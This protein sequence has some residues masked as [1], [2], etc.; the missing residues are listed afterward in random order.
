MRY[1]HV[2]WNIVS[3]VGKNKPY[4]CLI[5]SSKFHHSVLFI[6][7]SHLAYS[8][9]CHKEDKVSRTG[10]KY[11]SATLYIVLA[12]SENSFSVIDLSRSEFDIDIN[13]R[14]LDMSPLGNHE[15]A[16]HSRVLMPVLLSA[17]AIPISMLFWIINVAY[18]ILWPDSRKFMEGFV[19]S[20]MKR[21]SS[22]Y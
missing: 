9:C 13:L 8:R 5:H 7:K 11:F 17:C 2:A 3:T 16:G 1:L 18:S 6:L 12:F 4:T 22:N 15:E 20:M 14:K 10:K 21:Y 19:Y